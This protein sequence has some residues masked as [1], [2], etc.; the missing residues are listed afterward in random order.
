M[1][2][3]ERARVRTGAAIPV[4]RCGIGRSESA[5]EEV[6]EALSQL[7]RAVVRKR[8]RKDRLNLRRPIRVDMQLRANLPPGGWSMTESVRASKFGG[9]IPTVLAVLAIPAIPSGVVF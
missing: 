3:Q 1:A 7:G 2:L 8:A 4:A 9:S 6:T 5:V